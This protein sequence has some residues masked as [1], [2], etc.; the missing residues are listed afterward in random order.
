M[1]HIFSD[2]IGVFMDMYLDD[3]VIYLDTPE[4]H[5]WHVK[6]VID[7]L[8]ENKFFL[9]F[10]KLQLFNDKL[11]I[12][13]HVIDANGIQMGYQPQWEWTLL[14]VCMGPSK[15]FCIKGQSGG[16]PCGSD[17]LYGCTSIAPSPKTSLVLA[18]SYNLTNVS[19]FCFLTD[20]LPLFSSGFSDVQC[21]AGLT[22]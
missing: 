8:W 16:G 10:N 14:T 1:N 21:G 20:F 4:E 13:G 17:E 7:W 2:Y 19:S 9:S 18:L 22:P 6:L 15:P 12:L 11:H 5:V 3:I